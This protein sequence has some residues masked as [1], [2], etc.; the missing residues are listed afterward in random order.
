ML[1]SDD[2]IF[3]AGAHGMVGH[4]LVRLLKAQGFEDLLTPRRSELDLIDQKA[5]REYIRAHRPQ[6]IVIAAARVGGILANSS[7]PAAF[8][9][10]NAMMACNLIHEAHSANVQRLMFLGSSC[11]YPKFA[12][13]PIVEEALLSSSLEPTNEAYA[14]AKI[15]G[16]KLCHF[17]AT[18]YGRNY[19]AA[20]PTNLYG[21]GD[22]YHPDHS[23]VIPALLRRIHEAK[24]QSA[25]EV[26]IWGTGH[27]KRE[28]LY[29][30]DL[31][32][33]LLFL[34]RHYTDPFHINVGSA[35]EVTILTLAAT[36]ARTVGFTGRIIT[37]PSK[38]DGTPRKKTC[39]AR[40]S[41]LGWQERTPLPTGLSLTYSDFLA[42]L[43]SLREK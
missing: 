29:V 31:A 26:I 43:H 23:H 9:Y 7:Y 35:S 22:N 21:P 19:I 17:Y 8:L 30:D 20:M 37:D 16:V 12:P 40:L 39:T 4:A 5:V 36:I 28:F 27:A 2:R 42:S 25:S 24:V 13:Q 10:E 15:V 34:L 6:V 32:D 14:L 18:E 11:I 38:P 1:N 41:A 33:A 3:I